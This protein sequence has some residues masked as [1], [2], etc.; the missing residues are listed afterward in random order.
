ML[1]SWALGALGLKR[2]QYLLR[3]QSI[4]ARCV[5]GFLGALHSAWL[6][7]LALSFSAMSGK[8][9]Y[10]SSKPLFQKLEKEDHYRTQ[11]LILLQ[12]LDDRPHVKYTIHCLSQKQYSI[13]TILLMTIIYL[14]ILRSKSMYRWV[15]QQCLCEERKQ[16]FVISQIPSSNAENICVRYGKLVCIYW[17]NSP[18][19]PWY[20]QMVLKKPTIMTWLLFY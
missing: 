9:C 8:S 6:H 16:N 14:Q 7:I 13:Y 12:E 17:V 1:K 18:V 20:N 3:L 19:Q 4:R 15:G 2:K 11:V 5:A 10:L